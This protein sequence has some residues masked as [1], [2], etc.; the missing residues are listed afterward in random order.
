MKKF[1]ILFAPLLL[2]IPILA[3]SQQPILIVELSSNGEATVTQILEAK[4]IVS[5]INLPLISDKISKVLATDER[6]VLL[7]TTQNGNSLNIAT[8]GASG[9]TLTYKAEITSFDSQ[10][11]NVSYDA[12]TETV[13]ALPQLATIVSVSSIPID[14]EENAVIMPPGPV[15]ITY[16]ISQVSSKTFFVLEGG[17]NHPVEITSASKI[18]DFF[19]Q[20]NEI[21]FRVS[22]SET[23][24]VIVPSIVIPNPI[25]VSLNGD[26]VSFNPYYKNG[27]HNWI[28]IDPHESGII[29]ISGDV[30]ASQII[31]ENPIPDVNDGGND[32]IFLT[33]GI[34]LGVLAMG[35]V[36]FRK[37]FKIGLVRTNTSKGSNRP[38]K[39]SKRHKK[40]VK[41]RHIGIFALAFLP[42]LFAIPS[43]FGQ[44]AEDNPGIPNAASHA[45]SSFELMDLITNGQNEAATLSSI[46]EN[47]GLNQSLLDDYTDALEE[48]ASLAAIS[49]YSGAQAA[50]DGADA[51]LVDVYAEIY[52]EVDSQQNARYDH[53]VDDAIESI[54]T[55]LDLQEQG[56]ISLSDVVIKEL[57]ATLDI[58][59]SGDTEAILGVT[60]ET[61][62][63]GLTFT[64]HPGLD[65]ASPKA[66][67]SDNAKG[68]GLTDEGMPAAFQNLPY[69]IKAKFGF[70]TDNNIGA[71]SIDGE[72]NGDGENN[73]ESNGDVSIFSFLKNFGVALDNANPDNNGKGVGLGVGPNAPGLADKPI[74]WFLDPGFS[75]DDEFAPPPFAEDFEPG[76]YG[77]DIAAQK[78]AEAQKRAEDGKAHSQGSGGPPEEPP[79]GSGG[80]PPGKGGGKP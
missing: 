42:L 18:N 69:K 30:R 34:I 49:D 4:S 14:I 12:E 15:S 64:M 58:L 1:A 33:V 75:P 16:T 72:T 41:S 26:E 47:N 32:F 31:S 6:G 77:K 7:K 20:S 5:S 71:Q 68:V 66:K 3:E 37:Y 36:V 60:S 51:L 28:R 57:Q 13:V 76:K 73:G 10:A 2:F 17:Q 19:Q 56:L 74:Y 9:I 43:A 53:F 67:A 54:N 27:T 52:A 80:P 61:S 79:G 24:L 44:V 65:N 40:N 22:S 23:L 55:I 29:E 50:L 45:N 48:A 11:W 46:I 63:V 78:K 21:R 8:L 59:Q 38:N 62:D 25:G 39:L 70:S 35:Y